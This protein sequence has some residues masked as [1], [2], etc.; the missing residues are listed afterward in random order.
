MVNLQYG[1]APAM[2]TCQIALQPIAAA[3]MRILLSQQG[4]DT[5]V[6][7]H[8]T[9]LPRVGA[10]LRAH[11]GLEQILGETS[12]NITADEEGWVEHGGWRLTLPAG[13]RCTWPVLP[14]NPYRKDGYASFEEGLIVISMPLSSSLDRCLTLT[15]P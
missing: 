2:V 6:Q 5:D 10:T 9:L 3:E 8:L 14:H 11:N 12:I 15:I 7:T 13:S 4:G 1:T